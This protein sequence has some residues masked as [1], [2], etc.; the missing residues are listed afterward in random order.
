VRLA[1]V[2][3]LVTLALAP[4]AGA[5]KTTGRQWRTGTIRYANI[6]PDYEWP[7]RQAVAAWNGSGAR[8]SFVRVPRAQADL[9]VGARLEVGDKREA[10]LAQTY[11]VNRWITSATVFIRSGTS[12]YAAAQILAHELGHVVGLDHEDRACVT[13]NSTLYIDH[14]FRCAAPPAGTWRCG[15]VT[16]DDAAAAAHLYGGAAHGPPREFCAAALSG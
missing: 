5:W 16:K 6:A 10:G 13:M 11:S 3:L 7:L 2:A 8:V 12:Q 9:V 15:L 14:P 4:S 1:I